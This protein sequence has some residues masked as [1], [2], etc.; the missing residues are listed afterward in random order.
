MSFV[1][2]ANVAMGRR[3]LDDKSDGLISSS[4]SLLFPR[5]QATVSKL[6][7]ASLAFFTAGE[8]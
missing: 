5:D 1:V 4:S 2:V 7:M 8:R 3:L 6:A